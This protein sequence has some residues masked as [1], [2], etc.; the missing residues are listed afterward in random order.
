MYNNHNEFDRW[1]NNREPIYTSYRVTDE[2]EKPVKKARP[3][4]KV[5]ALC[6]CCALLGGLAGLGGGA[7]MGAIGPLGE[8][9]IY[10]GEHTP[11][12]VTV[13]NVPSPTQLTPAQVYGAN[14]D[15]CVG[16]TVSTTTNV[17]GNYT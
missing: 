4:A 3:R 9:T 5:V 7:L 2:V 12:A 16:I 14:V 1:Q 15:A 17:F 8:T 10:Y 11:V 13:A 6:L